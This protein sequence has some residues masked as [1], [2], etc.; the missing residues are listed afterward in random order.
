MSEL[1]APAVNYTEN[2][3]PMDHVKQDIWR[4][5]H[6]RFK[7]IPGGRHFLN[8]DNNVPPLGQILVNKPLAALLKRLGHEGPQV[9]YKECVAEG[10]VEAVH[11]AGGV[12]STEDLSDHLES[13]EPI[14]TEPA[15]TTYRE[16]SVH[17]TT[18]P[19]QGAVLLEA[20]NI[21]KNFDLKDVK[22][23]PGQFEHVVIEAL[24]HSIA[25]GL[26]Y[27]G[28]PC[29]GGSLNE[30]LSHQRARNSATMVDFD[31]PAGSRPSWSTCGGG[32]RLKSSSPGLVSPGEGCP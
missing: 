9:I 6:N 8:E 22:H 16:V 3:F 13:T 1:L 24:R 26:R 15:S 32:Q 19:T 18:L 23:I 20:L 29:T 7:R 5:M 12:L 2:G 10:I 21:L 14:E 27:V 31:R 17:T 28:D 11:R 25:D 30:M 4:A